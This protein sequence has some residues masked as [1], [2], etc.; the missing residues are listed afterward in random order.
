MLPLLII[1]YNRPH[2]FQKLIN[3]LK[4]IKPKN[5]YI[6]CDG[7]KSNVMDKHNV[8]L[9][10]EKIKFIDWSCKVTTLFQK[11]NLGCKKGVITAID[12][13]FDN[14][15]MGV[16]LEDDCIPNDNFFKFCYELLNMYKNNHNIASIGGQH[17]M[18]N[19]HLIEESYF[20]SRHFHCWGW[21][22]WARSWNNF[23]PT[24][25]KWKKFGSFTW[26]YKLC[27]K[28]LIFTYYW[29]KIFNDCYKNKIDSWAY[30][31]LF[32][33]ISEKKLTILP[34]KNLVKNI[35]FGKSSTH[36]SQGNYYTEN[37][38]LETMKFPLLHQTIFKPDVISDS[39]TDINIFE[40]TIWKIIKAAILRRKFFKFIIVTIKKL[41]K[42]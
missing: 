26:L 14:N 27:N 11:K 20:F 6:A 37:L 8:A 3:T 2:N 42:S 16:I 40:I 38:E 12:W 31:F 1:I 22:T 25:A 21:A 32:Y 29:Y 36:T 5:I 13:F 33:I 17:F 19:K 28:N 39:W 23:D 10:R 15:E 9:T 18:G 24:M 7:P 30:R 35:G 34:S 41:F 4:K